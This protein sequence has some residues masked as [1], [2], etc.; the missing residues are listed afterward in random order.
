MSLLQ[1]S[2]LTPIIKLIIGLKTVVVIKNM[3]NA[4]IFGI[5]N[6]IDVTDN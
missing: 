1:T 3:I 5:Q 2:Y 4:P 6:V